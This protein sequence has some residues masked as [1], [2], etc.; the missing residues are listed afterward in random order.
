MTE[1]QTV[2]AVAEIDKPQ[3]VGFREKSSRSAVG[4]EEIRARRGGNDSCC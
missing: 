4:C 3:E 1:F 2:F